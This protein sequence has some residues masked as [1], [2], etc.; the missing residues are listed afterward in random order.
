MDI[1]PLFAVD[2][3][4]LLENGKIQEAIDLCLLGLEE[5][6]GYPAAEAVLAKAYKLIG[7]EEK[8]DEIIE[9]AVAKKPNI[10]SIQKVKNTS[11]EEILEQNQRFVSA[12]STISEDDK[13]EFFDDSEIDSESE[14]EWS[15]NEDTEELDSELANHLEENTNSEESS[16]DD[17]NEKV[18]NSEIDNLLSNFN[19]EDEA[20]DNESADFFDENSVETVED[21]GNYSDEIIDQETKIGESAI[22]ESQENQEIELSEFESLEE[23][24]Q[25]SNL[26]FTEESN[27]GSSEKTVDLDT[28]ENE[29]DTLGQ[30]IESSEETVSEDYFDDG[31]ELDFSEFDS[32][33]QELNEESELEFSIETNDK[34]SEESFDLDSLENDLESLDKEIESSED[35][36][37]E[38]YFEDGEEL[39][40]SEFDSFGEELSEE[41]ELKFSKETNDETSEES[42]DLDSLESDLESLD[43]EIESNEETVSE[44]YFE[45]GEELDF[46]EFDS[47]GEELSV[48]DELDFSEEKSI[49]TIENEDL[50][51]EEI[52]QL[53]EPEEIEISAYDID[54]IPGL[55]FPKKL[56]D[57][58]SIVFDKSFQNNFIPEI[59]NKFS[60]KKKVEFYRQLKLQEVEAPSVLEMSLKYIKEEENDEKYEV[61]KL[62]NPS[63][64]I[65][66]TVIT[67]I[68]P[69]QIATPTL[70]SIYESQGAISD[71]IDIYEKLLVSDSSK[72]AFYQQKILELKG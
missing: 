42:F 16:F 27:V 9:K 14:I 53:E 51:F 1:S 43:K 31:E 28:I 54:L 59:E 70:A 4:E 58:D 19:N 62:A 68:R 48:E 26:E 29:L 11:K 45:D 18:D 32:D 71:A 72:S 21:F 7:D 56:L 10:R 30:E 64:E 35:T 37:S 3:E 15:E 33:D 17:L 63:Q 55:R 6:P 52:N 41:N 34:S 61:E 8:A 25:E 2:A 69:N 12:K 67:E 23:V 57:F 22:N 47:F 24:N 46:S 20:E 40:F 5:F 65:I 44:D 60:D 13:I 50:E 39:D 49:E 66:P 36:V 38:D